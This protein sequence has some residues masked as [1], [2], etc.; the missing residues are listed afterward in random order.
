MIDSNQKQQQQKHLLYWQSSYSFPFSDFSEVLKIDASMQGAKIIT[1]LQIECTKT[2][3]LKTDYA[4]ADGSKPG[5][6]MGIWTFS[7]LELL[8]VWGLPH[9]SID[10]GASQIP[11]IWTL[12]SWEVSVPWSLCSQPWPFPTCVSISKAKPTHYSALIVSS[13]RCLQVEL[14][15]IF[16]LLLH[17]YFKNKNTLYFNNLPITLLLSCWP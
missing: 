3:F 17:L 4:P 7:K 2:V 5:K 1:F 13:C 8:C 15:L 12:S 11:Q 10:V 6:Q 16:S 9:P 14:I